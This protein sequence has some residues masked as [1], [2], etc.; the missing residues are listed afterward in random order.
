M[1]VKDVE[2]LGLGEATE[3]Y[4]KKYWNVICGDD[5]RFQAMAEML[6]DQ[7]VNRGPMKA[8]KILQKA[9][10]AR[11]DGVMGPETM[12]LINAKDFTVTYFKAL[13]LS[14]VDIVVNTPS[15]AVFL[16]GWLRRTHGYLNG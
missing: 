12:S 4:R 9:I 11:V 10:N 1:S 7:A 3:I 13:Q 14:Y 6:F 5:I 2:E 8:I 15:Q 16:K